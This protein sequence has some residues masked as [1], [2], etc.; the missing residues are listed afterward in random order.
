MLNFFFHILAVCILSEKCTFI[1]GTHFGIRSLNLG[2]L[3]FF[4]SVYVLCSNPLSKEQL[5]NI[6]FHGGGLSPLLVSLAV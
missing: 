3:V 4:R 5:A 1:S 2:G 6:F